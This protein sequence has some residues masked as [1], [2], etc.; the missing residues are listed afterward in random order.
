MSLGGHVVPGVTLLLYGLWWA[1]VAIWTDIKK[2]AKKNTA[3]SAAVFF[4]NTTEKSSDC[5]AVEQSLRNKSWIPAPCCPRIPVEPVMKIVLIMLLL[6]IEAF[7]ADDNGHTYFKVYTFRNEEGTL[8]NLDNLFHLLLYSTII[9]SGV[10]DLLSLCIRLPNKTSNFFLFL[11]VLTAGLVFYFHIEGASRLMFHVHIL[12]V[13]VFGLAAIL[14][15]IRMYK[16][17]ASIFPINIGFAFCLILNGIWLIQIG[18]D[19]FPP[20]GSSDPLKAVNNNIPLQYMSACFT[21]HIA[22][23]SVFL[24]LMWLL[25]SFLASRWLKRKYP[26]KEEEVHNPLING[27]TEAETTHNEFADA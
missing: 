10:I 6:P 5:D 4:Q 19:I 24:L 17:L 16:D 7:M 13:P 25:V 8:T 21:L 12:L 3:N 27:G 15:L 14:L 2:R 22:V 9:L 26:S 1:L 20:Q 23:V 18:V 11:A